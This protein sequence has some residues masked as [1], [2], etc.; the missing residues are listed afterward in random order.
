MFSL[1]EGTED[2]INAEAACTTDGGLPQV[3]FSP[4]GLSEV[5]ACHELLHLKCEYEGYP[6]HRL[7]FVPQSVEEWAISDGVTEIVSLVEH[8]VIY[9]KM[10]KLGFDPHEEFER[11]VVG[12]LLRR[13]VEL[14]ELAETGQMNAS[15]SM[16]LMVWTARTLVE[17]RT[18]K[19]RKRFLRET[20]WF[21]EEFSRGSRVA[22]GVKNS[23]LGPHACKNA[24]VSSL[25]IL[26]IRR[27]AYDITVGP[28]K[29]AA[30]FEDKKV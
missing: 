11:K 1:G 30:Y 10:E 3:I 20:G 13:L 12:N 27:D 7:R 28:R 26:G 18:L 17:T 24:I 4:N 21:R 15:G 19:V 2:M 16:N 5:N 8:R 22:R 25:D 14:Q 29:A 23:G 9:P 6:R